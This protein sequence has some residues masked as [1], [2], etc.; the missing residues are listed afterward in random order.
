MTEHLHLLT[1]T[2]QNDSAW[3][4]TGDHHWVGYFVSL[5]G[6]LEIVG[7]VM[8]QT[9]PL[10][11]RLLNQKNHSSVEYQFQVRPCKLHKVLVIKG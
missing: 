3:H 2:G 5:P 10:H 6:S 8:S 7:M 1:Y 9:Y 11:P 4:E